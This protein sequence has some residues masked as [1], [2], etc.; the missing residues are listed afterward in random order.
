MRVLTL[1]LWGRR[2]QWPKRREVITEAV[3]QLNPDLVAF[4]ESIK[5]AHDDQVAELLESDYRLVHQAEREPDGQG[6]AIGSRWEVTAVYEVDLN[7]TPRTAGTACTSLI[8]EIAAPI[9]PVLLVNHFPSWQLSGMSTSES[10]KR[11]PLPGRSRRSWA[12]G[13][14]M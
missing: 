5:T 4:Q 7:V 3:R 12:T 9:G 6:I 2:G 10:C 1:N 13:P 8:A 14:C 11:W